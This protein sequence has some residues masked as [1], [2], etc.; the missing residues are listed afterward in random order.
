MEWRRRLSGEGGLKLNKAV[1]EGAMWKEVT[2]EG[3]LL[4]RTIRERDMREETEGTAVRKRLKE[5]TERR[6]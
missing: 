5:E 2:R 1:K 6:T 3:A 4:E